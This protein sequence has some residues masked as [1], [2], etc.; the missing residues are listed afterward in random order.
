MCS[1]PG[2][3]SMLGLEKVERVVTMVS[4]RQGLSAQMDLSRFWDSATEIAG[5]CGSIADKMSGIMPQDAY[6]LG[7]FHDAGIPLMIQKY[8]DYKAVLKSAAAR[9]G[10]PETKTEDERYGTNHAEVGYFLCRH[11][12]LPDPICDAIYFHHEYCDSFDTSHGSSD[13]IMSLIA[14]LKMAERIS[15]TFRQAWRN[16]NNLEWDR[17][18][19]QILQ[20]MGMEMEEFTELQDE[21]IEMLG[22]S[23]N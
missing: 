9:E 11:W 2:A 4:L 5:L 1:V 6:T 15:A 16:E 18:G 17:I 21:M 10:V 3:V 22:V 19:E 7:L 8:E 12:C 13:E 20:F 23:S 14:V